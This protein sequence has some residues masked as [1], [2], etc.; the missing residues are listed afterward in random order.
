MLTRCPDCETTFRVTPEQ[1]KARQGRVRCGQCQGVF[2]ALET[3]IEEAPAIAA[4]IEEPA[5]EPAA[6]AEET[7]VPPAPTPEETPEVPAAAET[8]AEPETLVDYEPT[9]DDIFPPEAPRRRAWPW[10]LGSLLA[11]LALSVQALFH[12]R[13]ELAVLL[14]ESRPALKAM[15]KTFGCDLPL[16]RKVELV[17]IETSDLHPDPADATRLQLVATLKNRAPFAQEYPHLELTL[18]DTADKALLRKVLAPVDYLP[19][20]KSPAPGFA[21]GGDLAV[22][23]ALEVK[24]LAPVGYRLYVFYP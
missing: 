23:L 6:E 22:S 11:L 2:N 13:V 10:V 21:A 24:D 17:G 8:P 12:Y 20:G 4:P 5:P 9:L 14:P 1:L 3:L 16:P 15:C 19:P 18:T 7:A